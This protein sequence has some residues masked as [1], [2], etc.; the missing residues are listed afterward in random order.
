MIES[1]ES[2]DVRETVMRAFADPQVMRDVILKLVRIKPEQ[3]FDG[4]GIICAWPTRQCPVGCDYCF[5]DSNMS[6]RDEETQWTDEGVEKLIQLL[7]DANMGELR[8]SGGGDPFVERRKINRLV[9]AGKVDEFTLVTSA[10][11]AKSKD[12]AALV[13]R[14]LFENHSRNPHHPVTSLRMSVDEHHL[15]KL[16]PDGMQYMLN[17]VEHYMTNHPHDE[18]FRL[19]LHTMVGDPAIDDLLA[20]LPVTKRSELPCRQAHGPHRSEKMEIVELEGGLTVKIRHAKR[21]YSDPEIDMNSPEA[22]A[23]IASCEQDI[24]ELHDGHVGLV[25]NEGEA[26]GLNFGM[27]HDGRLLSWG[28]TPPDYEHDIYSDDYATMEERAYGDVITLG[29]LEKGDAY[30][31]NIVGEVNPHASRRVYGIGLRDFYSRILFEESKTRLYAA[32]RVLQDYV[33]DGRVTEDE[34]LK[35]PTTLQTL[36]NAPQEL[37]AEAHESS[38]FTIVE[39]YASNPHVTSADLLRLHTLIQRGHYDIS[40]EEMANAVMSDERIASN[41][42]QGFVA[43]LIEKDF[44]PLEALTTN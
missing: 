41:V 8:L 13:L 43:A 35:W 3:R 27:Y 39:Q 6:G 20:R 15:T 30:V 28:G 17:V 29:T 9:E 16:K 2:A 22:A 34:I 26:T 21:F 14:E 33:R 25:Y 23:N 44:V 18:R 42:R 40:E 32:V 7:S 4:K 11:W 37:L 31:R 1:I 12:K 10:F 5:F 38:S 19:T 24:E 36:I